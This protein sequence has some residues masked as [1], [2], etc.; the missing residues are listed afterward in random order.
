MLIQTILRYIE[1]IHANTSYY[2]VQAHLINRGK[3]SKKGDTVIGVDIARNAAER[4]KKR[5]HALSF[6]VCTL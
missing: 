2:R 1:E 3:H 6:A 4:I 5:T